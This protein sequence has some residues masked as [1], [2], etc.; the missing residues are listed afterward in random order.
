MLWIVLAIPILMLSFPSAG[1]AQISSFPY[2]QNFESGTG[3]WTHGGN[4][5]H[6]RWGTP[7]GSFSGAYSGSYAMVCQGT[8]CGYYDYAY[9]YLD[10]P[11]IDCS[12]IGYDPVLRYWQWYDT[13][14]CCDP[15]DVQYSLDGGWSWITLEEN[16]GSNYGYTQSAFKL[17]GAAGNP[18]VRVRFLF[19]S[20]VS[21]TY[22][23]WAVDDIELGNFPVI[24]ATPT[25]NWPW[26]MGIA[27]VTFGSIN[28][29]SCYACN[30]NYTDYSGYLTTNV[31]TNQTYQI[32]VYTEGYEQWVM[33]YIDWNQDGQF[34][35]PGEAYDLDYSY[36][37]TVSALITVPAFAV[38]GPTR[39]RV[40]TEYYWYGAPPPCGPVNYGE[41][42]DYGLVVISAN[43]PRI[44]LAPSAMTFEA[45]GGGGLPAAQTL[46]I[47]NVGADQPMPWAVTTIASPAPNWLNAGPPASGTLP[48]YNQ[49]QTTPVQPNRTNLAYALPY[50]S[51]SGTVRVT[52]TFADNSPQDVPVTY[53]VVPPTHININTELL[54]VK[55]LFKKPVQ[56]KKVYVQNTGGHYSG[57]QLSW[58]VSTTTPWI[59]FVG[60]T[61]GVEGGF[62]TILVDPGILS[63]GTYS[64]SIT[65]TGE[66]S[67][68][69]V[70]AD[71][72]PATIEVNMEIEPDQNY[73]QTK[74]ITTPG[75]YEFVN[76]YDQEVAEVTLNSGSLGSM[77]VN[78]FP[79]QLPPG[80]SR[81][82]YVRRYFTF[83]CTNRT[84]NINLELYYTGSEA[85]LGG[86][87]RPELLT[88]YRQPVWGGA[89]QNM[90]GTSNPLEN[91]VKIMNITN[92]D[93]SW[94]CASPWYPKQVTLASFS[95][96]QSGRS[97]VSVEWKSKLVMSDEGFILQR[98]SLGASDWTD[99]A[100]VPST[101]KGEYDV[102][103]RDVPK[104]AY[105][106]Q[107]I[108]LDK[109]GNEIASQIV[110]LAVGD[111]PREFGLVQ[112]YPNPFSGSTSIDFML[113]ENGRVTLTV[114][115]LVGQ[116]VARVIDGRELA[117][118]SHSVSFVN[119]SLDPGTYVYRLSCNGRQLSKRMTIIR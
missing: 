43:A 109:D 56:A 51:Y 74:S 58:T 11:S 52:S 111:T 31:L 87:T 6:W 30:N 10:S 22:S 7:C 72:S 94:V 55:V 45:E 113:P 2:F 42:E 105:Q 97:D 13:E 36:Y 69:H 76:G 66:N 92:L 85:A 1:Q 12:S 21:I 14:S 9:E 116:E 103:D 104:G 108:G 50:T 29:W 77:T 48:G 54:T 61:S 23:G 80:S 68:T 57:G 64:G 99:V 15:C 27:N 86:V 95:A 98:A 70:P 106:Y 93:G 8:W 38:P 18:D 84:F 60:P 112:N 33:V 110:T 82:R 39:M 53:N 20:D 59:S 26:Y 89:W 100:V 37:N 32:N 88:G 25:C 83:S 24:C 114:H 119:A 107:V 34:D 102:I 49:P 118:G 17:T 91:N 28:N 40:R 65:L 46:T 3:G 41:A 73:S 62:F 75:T 117:A 78:M 67:V 79:A 71:N 96:M 16:R 19:Q 47:N 90:G 63:P 4:F 35:G 44:A 101:I 115:N 5:D 81:L